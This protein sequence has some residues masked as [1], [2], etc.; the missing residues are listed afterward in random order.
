MRLVLIAR[1]GNDV[2]SLCLNM[3]ATVMYSYE[4][5]YSTLTPRAYGERRGSESE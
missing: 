5:S 3:C 2:P 1:T 4:Q